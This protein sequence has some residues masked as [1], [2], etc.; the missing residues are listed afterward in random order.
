[1]GGPVMK[2]NYFSLS[3]S[4]D[5]AR[6]GGDAC[7][8]DGRIPVWVL[9]NYQRSGGSDTDLL[10]EYPSLT[11]ADLEAAREYA[12]SHPEEIERAIRENEEEDMASCAL[13]GA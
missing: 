11:P 1:M 5:P 7:I 3:I 10:R 2:P 4:K 6:C 8:R 13:T 9:V 12:V